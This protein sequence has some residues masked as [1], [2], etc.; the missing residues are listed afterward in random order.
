MAT[1][2]DGNS[3]MDSND[4]PRAIAMPFTLSKLA[5]FA[6]DPESRELYNTKSFGLRVDLKECCTFLMAPSDRRRVLRRECYDLSDVC[7]IASFNGHLDCLQQA[8]VAGIPWDWRTTEVACRSGNIEC[9]MYVHTNG[10]ETGGY[11]SVLAAACAGKIQTLEYCWNHGFKFPRNLCTLIARFGSIES[12]RYIRALG[13]SWD[14]STTAAAARFNQLEFL[15]YLH[16]HDCPWDATT[17]YYAA[18]HGNLECLKYAHENDCEWDMRTCHGAAQFGYIEC[19]KYAHTNGCEWN[20]LTTM[21]AAINKQHHCF[22]Y[23]LQ[24]GCP[25]PDWLTWERISENKL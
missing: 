23:A 17:C 16:Q 8:H 24:N 2:G 12:L 6:C 20:I 13:F 11:V 5:Y 1:A 9:L 3:P 10:C 19:L 7:S 14:V 18:Q 15:K 25:W 22:S 4:T 21:M